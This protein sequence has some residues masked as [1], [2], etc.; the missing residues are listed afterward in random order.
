MNTMSDDSVNTKATIKYVDLSG[1]FFAIES[2]TGEKLDPVNLPQEYQKDGLEIRV[3]GQRKPDYDS[4]HMW[5]SVFEITD[6][7]KKED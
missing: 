5:G 1:G 3:T 6:I 4:V 7:K 2:K